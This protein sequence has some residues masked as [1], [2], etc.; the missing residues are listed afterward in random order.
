ARQAPTSDRPGSVC[1]ATPELPAPPA[2][3]FGEHPW[4]RLSA[5]WG[6]FARLAIRQGP[7]CCPPPSG[8]GAK[9]VGEVSLRDRRS[10]AWLA[11]TF[12]TRREPIRQDES[13]RQEGRR[14]WSRV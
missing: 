11:A 5:R 7:N 4:H 1:P 12:S 3:S 10:F 8:S 6:R 14:G 9:N 13:H 2:G